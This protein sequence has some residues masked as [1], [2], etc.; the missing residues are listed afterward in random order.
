M[1]W[2]RRRLLGGSLA[3]ACVGC[4]GDDTSSLVASPDPADPT[5]ASAPG[6]SIVGTTPSSD[7][8]P[9][10]LAASVEVGSLTE[11]RAASAPTY[12]PAARSWLVALTE[13]EAEALAATADGSL[14]PGLEHGVLALAEKCPHLG[15]RVPFC[16]SSGWFE[17]MCHGSMYTRVGEHRE[18]PGPRGLDAH[19]VVVVDGVVSIDIRNVIRGAPPGTVVVEQAP[20]GPHCVDGNNH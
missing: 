20:S 4:S 13:Q 19:P 6:V 11:L 10:P 17:C 15:C 8:V 5:D 14:L 1:R 18:G 2:S 12:A 3:V 16:D 7:R 9:P